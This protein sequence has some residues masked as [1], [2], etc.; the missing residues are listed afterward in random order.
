PYAVCLRLLSIENTKDKR[1]DLTLREAEVIRD[2]LMFYGNARR[3]TPVSHE[4]FDVHKKVLQEITPTGSRQ[5]TDGEDQ[6]IKSALNRSSTL[7]SKGRF[8][9]PE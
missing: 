3:G 6:A 5:M 7:V 9:G 2:A 4:A 1:M 8:A